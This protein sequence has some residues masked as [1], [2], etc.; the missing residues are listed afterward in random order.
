MTKRNGVTA[1]FIASILSLAGSEVNAGLL[2][3]A[4]TGIRDKASDATGRFN[5]M[6][7]CLQKLA[8][9][10]ESRPQIPSGAVVA[11]D[12]ECPNEGW[13]L[14]DRAGGRFIVGAGHHSNRDT[15]GKLLTIYSKPR[16]DGGEEQHTLTVA[17]IPAHSHPIL[18]TDSK[19]GDGNFVNWT[20]MGSPN[21]KSTGA[22][23]A[24]VGKSQSHNN[25]PPYIALYFCKKK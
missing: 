13:E 16:L 8:D 7:E 17:E 11:F 3:D 14:Y 2:V 21:N 1:L 19:S 9:E 10:V 12:R 4:C 25:M 18:R 5:A 24:T 15:N 20:A 22:G 23:T 6:L